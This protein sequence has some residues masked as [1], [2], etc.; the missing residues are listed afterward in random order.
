MYN[1]AARLVRLRHFQLKHRCLE[2]GAGVLSKPDNLAAIEEV[3]HE[4]ADVVAGMWEEPD[5]AVE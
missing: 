1:P 2:Q 5:R 3:I 4:S